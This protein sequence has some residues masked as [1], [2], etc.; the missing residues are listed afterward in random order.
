MAVYNPWD[1]EDDQ[2][3]LSP[4]AL[5]QTP[6][7]TPAGAAPTSVTNPSSSGRFTNFAS[8]FNANPAAAAAGQNTVEGLGQ[9]AQRLQE[10]SAKDRG[11]VVSSAGAT[12]VMAPPKDP[13]AR[14]VEEANREKQAEYGY[15][16]NQYTGPAVEQVGQRF[17]QTGAKAEDTTR[18]LNQTRDAEGMKALQGGTGF[19]AALAYAGAGGQADTLRKRYAGLLGNV[20]KDANAA[21]SAVKTAQAT[22][23]QNAAAWDDIEAQKGAAWEKSDAARRVDEA[24]RVA[25]QGAA[26][27]NRMAQPAFNQ[28]RSLTRST[29]GDFAQTVL[30]L[31]DEQVA[32]SH[33][34]TLEEWDAAGRPNYGVDFGAY[35][36]TMTGRR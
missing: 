17:A 18:R 22:S 28:A 16:P 33:G 32:H 6:Q 35:K 27:A 7:E 34:M 1:E 5:G 8:Y 3:N 2:A 21:T 36:R 29:R 11:S 12:T 10:Q 30:G 19:Q 9:Q 31:T 14:A 23:A 25:A 15:T 24:H 26:A 4:A 13:A 20:E